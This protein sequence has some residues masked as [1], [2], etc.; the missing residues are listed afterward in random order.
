[1]DLA[2][3]GWVSGDTHIAKIYHNDGSDA[4]TDIGAGL[5]GVRRCSLSWGDYNNDGRIDLASAGAT[6]SAPPYAP[7]AK[8]Y[9]NDGIDVFTDINAGLVE[10]VD[11][12]LAWGDYDNDGDLD[13]ALAGYDGVSPISKIYR[14]DAGTFIDIGAD[15]V[16]VSDCSLA[17]TDFD[18][19]G[20]LDIA[21]AGWDGSNY[22][23]KIY[24]NDGGL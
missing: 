2:L 24:R 8:I 5:V 22:T 11:C 4:F 1:L 12:S 6:D 17:W 16:N 14:N 13:L 7:I 10:L 9:R 23:S 19:D 15:L 18:N 20:D 3:A 21:L